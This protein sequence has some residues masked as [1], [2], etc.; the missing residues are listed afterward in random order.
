MNSSGE[1]FHI[2]GFL[3]GERLRSFGHF[4]LSD[5]YTFVVSENFIKK[6]NLAKTKYP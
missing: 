3:S 1:W 4:F 5:T 6:R 2:G